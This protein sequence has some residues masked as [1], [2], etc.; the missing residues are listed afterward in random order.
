MIINEETGEILE[1]ETVPYEHRTPHP[2]VLFTFDIQ[3]VDDM[4]NYMK[5]MVDKR[6]I[7]GSNNDDLLRFFEGCLSNSIL[8]NEFFATKETMTVAQFK[9][10]R[11]LCDLIEYKNIIMITRSELCEKLECRDNHLNRKLKLVAPYIKVYNRKDGIRRGEIKIEVTPKFQ[12]IFDMSWY[13]V[14]RDD[15]IAD[16]YYPT[17][18]PQF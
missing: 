3:S 4:K 11:V 5:K 6:K 8:S 9:V 17:F 16:W 18:T 1:Y 7:R 2:E 15:A 13:D 12:Y 14:A 10:L